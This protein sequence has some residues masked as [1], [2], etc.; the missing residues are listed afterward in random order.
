MNAQR[1]GAENAMFVPLAARENEDVFV[2]VVMVEGNFAF[3][4]E[5]N[6]RGGWSHETVSVE[7]M[8]FH[9]F[10]EGLPCQAIRVFCDAEDVREFDDGG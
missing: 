10:P 7:A 8:N 3:F 5:S 2:S 4:P 1:S 6:E 9:S